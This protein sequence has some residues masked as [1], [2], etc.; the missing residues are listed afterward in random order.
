VRK[1]NPH[2]LFNTLNS[3]YALSRKQSEQT[4]EVVLQLSKLLRYML[5]ECKE[6]FVPLEKEWRII[7]DYI[8]LEKLRY[9]DRVEAVMKNDILRSDIMIAP[10]LFLP[11]VEN[12]FKH[13]A[14]NNR[15]HTDITHQH[16]HERRGAA[17]CSR[18]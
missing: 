11:L 15:N 16:F 2:F 13:G 7:E 6:P 8:A 14:G 12:A 4:P 3:I 1:T 5:Y 9:S 10:L 17:I 18:K